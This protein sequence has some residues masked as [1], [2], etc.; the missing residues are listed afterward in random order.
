VA[1]IQIS[2]SAALAFACFALGQLIQNVV[3]LVHPTALGPRRANTGGK[4]FQ[5]PS[6]PFDADVLGWLQEKGK[7]YQASVFGQPL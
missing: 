6:A 2:C 5:T 1:A 3:R 7:G 4:A